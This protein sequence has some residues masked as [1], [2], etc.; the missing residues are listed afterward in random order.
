MRLGGISLIARE[1]LWFKLQPSL[2]GVAV[3]SFFL[4][5]KW[6]KESLIHQMLIDMK[7]PQDKILPSEIYEMMEW[8]LCLFLIANAVWMTYVALKMTTAQWLFWKTAGF[9]IV[10]IPFMLLEM[11]F[12]LRKVRRK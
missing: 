10:F 3:A 7:T 4:F 5:K 2:T 6:K 8:H 11:V 9:Y 1:G 12:I